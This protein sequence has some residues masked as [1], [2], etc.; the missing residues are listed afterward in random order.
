MLIHGKLHNV[1]RITDT[2]IEPLRA[3]CLRGQIYGDTKGRF[4]DGEWVTTS[5]IDEELPEGVFKTRFSVYKVV[6]WADAPV[7]APLNAYDK[8]D[9]VRRH[10]VLA[11]GP[12]KLAAYTVR[13]IETGEHGS[14]QF[15]MTYNNTVMAV[16]GAEA[17][18]LF[19]RFVADN[20]PAEE[21]QAAA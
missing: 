8:D 21:K 16:M 6:N 4:R 2:E 19:S 5:R 20:L 18:K 11:A 13:D 14:M 1:S 7:A 10:S 9:I 15:H 12:M 17:A 3:P